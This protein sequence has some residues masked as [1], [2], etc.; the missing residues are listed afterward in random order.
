MPTR[1]RRRSRHLRSRAPPHAF[2]LP[3]APNQHFPTAKSFLSHLKSISPAPN[4]IVISP[5][6]TQAPP[7]RPKISNPQTLDSIPNLCDELPLQEDA[8]AAAVGGSIAGDSPCHVAATSAACPTTTLP[9][10]LWSRRLV[11]PR[12]TAIHSTRVGNKLA[13]WYSATRHGGS[14]SMVG[15]NEHWCICRFYPNY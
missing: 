10:V 14:R 13:R 3:P 12:N 11:P 4:H 7:N 5:K 8:C 2:L 6:S 1:R 9:I 15:T